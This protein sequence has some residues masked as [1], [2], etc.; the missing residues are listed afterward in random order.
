MRTFPMAKMTDE[1]ANQQIPQKPAGKTVEERLEALERFAALN[2]AK[3][4][5]A[6]KLVLGEGLKS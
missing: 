5:K 3:I 4:D 6:V 2:N 1:T